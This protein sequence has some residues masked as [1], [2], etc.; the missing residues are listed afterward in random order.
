[1]RPVLVLTQ[2]DRPSGRG[3]KLAPSPVKILA[4]EYSLP[5]DQPERLR[6]DEQVAALRAAA[7]D[8]LIV[9]AYGLILPRRVLELPRLGCVNVHA[10]LLPRW[11]GAAPVERSMM[12]GDADTGVCL[13]QMDVG[14]DTGAV[15]DRQAIPVLD[16]ETGPELEARLADLGARRLA[17][18]LPAFLRGELAATPQDDRDATYAHKLTRAD[19]AIDWQAGA[20]AIARRIRALAGRMSV[21]VRLGGARLQLL[22]ATATPGASSSAPAGTIVGVKPTIDVACPDGILHIHRL[23]FTDRGKGTA[24]TASEAA[25][26]FATIIHPGARFDAEG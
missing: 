25:N 26:G 7:P 17:A 23:R 6:T 11:R 10:S 1:V 2:P 4:S 8:V 9:A 19:A 20:E 15:L 22:Q 24:L 16:A 13:M 18:L 14:L 5:I 3:R 12:A 21:E